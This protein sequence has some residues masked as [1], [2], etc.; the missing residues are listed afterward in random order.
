MS[1]LL[2][3]T[4]RW[5]RR[6]VLFLGLTQTVNMCV[7]N[8]I[9]VYDEELILYT[10]G[11]QC[12]RRTCSCLISIEQSCVPVNV[13]LKFYTPSNDCGCGRNTHNATI[14]YKE[15]SE[16]KTLSWIRA[17][18]ND[19]R[20]IRGVYEPFSISTTYSECDASYYLDLS[21]S[22][23]YASLSNRKV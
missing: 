23:L 12:T 4:E 20:T 11:P 5:R 7:E 22:R 13:K 6:L 14:I 8:S 3:C 1:K 21:S 9:Y 10:S 17:M 18:N 16:N 15:N 2:K 19:E